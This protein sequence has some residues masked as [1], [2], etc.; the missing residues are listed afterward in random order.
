VYTAL[1]F[2]SWYSNALGLPEVEHTFAWMR[3]APR[4]GYIGSDSSLVITRLARTDVP[5]LHPLFVQTVWRSH[6]PYR[7]Q[8]GLAGV[9]LA[10]IGAATGADA[11]CFA[12]AF[13]LLTAAVVAG[14]FAAAHR[15]L[16]PPTGDVACA[17]AALAPVFL[18][19]AASLYW[20]LFLM[21]LPF[22]LAWWLYPRAH[23]R[24]R[25]AALL[26]AVGA[27]VMLK[28]LCGY[29]FITAVVLGPLAAAW[30]HQHRG[31]EPLRRRAAFAAG[32]LAAGVVGFAAAMALHVAQA[33]AVLGE[34]GIAAIRDRAVR[35]TAGSVEAHET[36]AGI[37]AGAADLATAARCF[38]GYFGHRAISPPAAARALRRDVP[39]VAVVVAA[40]AFAV[41]AA[42]GRRRLPRDAGAL[43]GAVVLALASGVS[44]PALAVNHM[45]TH[46]QL[47]GL[48][49]ALPFLPVAFLAAG[50]TLRLAGGSRLGPVVLALV[51][52][53]GV[54]NVAGRERSEA[55]ARAAQERAEAT[56]AARL[57]DP[58][59]AFGSD[60][61]SVDSYR[62]I[63]E[64]HDRTLLELG[65]LDVS[66]ARPKDP[67]SV[68]V[69]GWAGGRVVVAVGRSVVPCPVTRWRRPDID[70]LIGKPTPGIGFRVVVPSAALAGGGRPRV[71]VVSEVDPTRVTEL[72]VP[73]GGATGGNG[74]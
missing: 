57:A 49:Y 19:F 72:A 23:T 35:R 4:T 14:V 28:G 32:L 2:A 63:D 31:A 55:A 41:A 67:G 53:A 52:G 22:A 59:P 1:L 12:A 6:E 7:S 46:P 9:V 65:L 26:A 61:G 42:V 56:V 24:R 73:P 27:A 16:G 50:Y 64:L 38:L 30:F 40:G 21:L 18:P 66:A 15:Q 62:P 71:F 44:W 3:C 45:C 29:E 54:A 60:G 58:A 70:G 48:V 10:P 39:L 69:E 47:D 25:K 43:A 11:A 8:F 36:R 74:Q 13:A 17:L 34:D 5:A 51:A 33:W 20:A 68:L 37:S